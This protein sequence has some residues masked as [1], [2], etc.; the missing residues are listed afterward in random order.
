MRRALPLF[1]PLCLAFAP[2]PFPKQRCADDSQRDLQAMQGEWTERFA[3]SATV[4]I[5]GDRMVYSSDSAWKLT[6]HTKANPRRVAATGVGSKLAGKARWGVY[7]LEKD[8]LTICWRQG[9]VS[10]PDWP[11]SL[12]PAQKGVWIEVFTPV[13]P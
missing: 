2:A 5:I 1:A 6:L 10:K 13:K 4:T 12:D 8:K 9:S 11:I 3:D 7:C